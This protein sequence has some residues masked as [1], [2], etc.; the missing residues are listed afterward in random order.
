M[1]VQNSRLETVTQHCSLGPLSNPWIQP[2]D[3]TNI[4]GITII[5]KLGFKSPIKLG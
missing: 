2:V 4:T 3:Q 1:L 5:I